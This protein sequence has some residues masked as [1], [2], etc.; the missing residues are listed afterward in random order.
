MSCVLW[1]V[2]YCDKPSAVFIISYSNSIIMPFNISPIK[3]FNGT[4]KTF[5]LFD[6][7][8][9]SV[10]DLPKFGIVFV[11]KGNVGLCAHRFLKLVA[12]FPTCLG[13]LYMVIHPYMER[14][15]LTVRSRYSALTPEIIVQLHS[16]LDFV[17]SISA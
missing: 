17:Q 5:P 16:A 14:S 9:T 1:D 11:P 7:S 3:I 15:G 13:C 10:L 4:I 12:V 2:L 6:L 8:F